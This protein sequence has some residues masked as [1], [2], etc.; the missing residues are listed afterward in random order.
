MIDKIDILLEN[1]KAKQAVY[2]YE[3]F[4]SGCYEKAEEIDDSGGNLGMFFEELFCSWIYGRQK[5]KYDPKETIDSVLKW[6]ENDD[7][8]FCYKIEKSIVKIFC[9][10]ELKIFE[11][12]IRSR[13]D[14]A[15]SL[16]DPKEDKRINNYSYPVRE[17]AGILKT[18]YNEKKDIKSYL[19]LCKKVGAKHLWFDFDEE[20]DVL[21]ISLERPQRAT[22][23]DI[24][25]DGIFL[26]LRDKEI[27]GITITNISK[28]FRKKD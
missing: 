21:Y 15:Y 22:D 14:D 5:A 20:A 7:Y 12:S 9:R 13:F 16:E 28:K 23:T 19:S 18:I 24:L 8:G 1:G 27:V 2:L 3:I 10:D 17:N 26:R 11:S 25:E 6:M 4:L